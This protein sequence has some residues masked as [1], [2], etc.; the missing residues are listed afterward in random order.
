MI[1]KK[2]NSN[3][4]QYVKYG[5]IGLALCF[6]LFIVYRQVSIKNSD[7]STKVLTQQ[8]IE[9]P[10]ALQENKTTNS[11]DKLDKEAKELME[12]EK[13]RAMKMQKL[14]ERKR[15]IKRTEV[16]QQRPLSPQENNSQNNTDETQKVSV[17]VKPVETTQNSTVTTKKD[18][19]KISKLFDGKKILEDKKVVKKMETFLTFDFTKIQTPID[20]KSI[21]K[22]MRVESDYFQIKKQKF[23]VGEKMGDFEIVKITKNRIRFKKDNTLFY[24]LR[25]FN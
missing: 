7:T 11:L 20:L 25:F 4:K 16:E 21:Q 8:K 10:K 2:K 9:E 5:S 13:K 3:A 1:E 19:N 18:K 14:S 17:V 12:I 22:D 15:V 6:I 23:F 24:D